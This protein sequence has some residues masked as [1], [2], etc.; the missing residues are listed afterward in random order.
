MKIKQDLEQTVLTLFLLKGS[1]LSI[2]KLDLGFLVEPKIRFKSKP[3]EQ[4][5]FFIYDPSGNAIEFKTFK[6]D[7]MV[8]EKF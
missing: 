4:G 8:F 6:K 3:G 5:T 2:K 1:L 7:S